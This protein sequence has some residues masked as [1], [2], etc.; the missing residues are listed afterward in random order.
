MGQM[1][2]VREP[3]E[4][5]ETKPNKKVLILDSY[6]QTKR[7]DFR[8]LGPNWMKKFWFKTVETKLNS[9][10]SDV[11]FGPNYLKLKHFEQIVKV[12]NDQNPN[13]SKSEPAKVR[14]LA[15]YCT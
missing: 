12:P 6:D 7:S 8:L 2:N 11:W 5:V 9:P 15:L 10:I 13:H 14:I 1:S 4:K 3:N